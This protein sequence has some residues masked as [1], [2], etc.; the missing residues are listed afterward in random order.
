MRPTFYTGMKWSKSRVEFRE[1]RL[2]TLRKQAFGN[3][4]NALESK[5]YGCY[6]AARMEFG[7]ATRNVRTHS[8]SFQLCSI[9]LATLS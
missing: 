9:F 2:E 6:M 1:Q 8:Y 7:T 3:F 5:S 4:S